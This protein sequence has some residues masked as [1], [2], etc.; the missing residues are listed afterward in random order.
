VNGLGARLVAEAR[1]VT[2][3]ALRDS[4]FYTLLAANALALVVSLVSALSMADMM[5]AFWAQSVMIG[6]TNVFRIIALQD[7]STEGLGGGD[8]GP[9]P[10]TTET[11]LGAAGLFAFFYGAFHYGYLL[12]IQDI[13]QQAGA[14]DPF[15]RFEW[16]LCAAGFAVNHLYSLWHNLAADA[17]GRPSLQTL[18]F[19]P[20]ARVVPM[21]LAGAVFYEV[22]SGAL[23]R[24]LFGAL[25]TWAD[26]TMH[27]IEH[28]ALRAG[29]LIPWPP[30][31]GRV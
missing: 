31:G 12:L 4:S 23:Q 24:V 20:V 11:K 28:H 1:E 19:M 30:F 6:V 8:D 17:A 10:E 15:R 9:P 26:V 7:F 2:G 22:P 13:A 29:K 14:A 25:K 3:E 5:A 16:W 18:L 27:A 21:H